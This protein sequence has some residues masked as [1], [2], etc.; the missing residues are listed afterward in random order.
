MTERRKTAPAGYLTKAEAAQRLR[1]SIRTLERYV[2]AERITPLRTPGGR[3][4]FIAAEVEAL[5]E[6][7]A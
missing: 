5:L 7:A 4:R 6:S 3:P 1:V 2:A